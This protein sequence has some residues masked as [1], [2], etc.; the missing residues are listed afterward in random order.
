MDV[1]SGFVTKGL[2]SSSLIDDDDGSGDRLF[3]PVGFPEFLSELFDC[4]EL[5]SALLVSWDTKNKKNKIVRLRIH[6][7]EDKRSRYN[8]IL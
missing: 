6:L 4:C 1:G 3:D 5:S 7:D 2:S 8:R